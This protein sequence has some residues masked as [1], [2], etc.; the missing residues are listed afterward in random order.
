MSAVS[1]DLAESPLGWLSRRP[2]PD[3]RPWID[4]A[5]LAAAERLR[6]DFTKGGLTPRITQT[7]EATGSRMRRTGVRGGLGDLGDM[8]MEARA[9]MNA[10]L[11]AVGP[12]LSGVLVDVCCFLKGLE[13]V[14]RERRW[15]P[16][17][18]KVILAL[19]LDRLAA[20]YGITRVAAGPETARPR[21]WG[22]ADYRPK[23]T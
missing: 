8:A 14:E 3:G 15:P 17:S 12:E 6:L 7:W 21:H 4:A 19:A 13:A 11:E 10:A 20:H 1:V 18:S 9:R 5:Q 16:R 23:I 22:T 2:G